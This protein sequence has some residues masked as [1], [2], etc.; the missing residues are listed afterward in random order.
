V[1]AVKVPMPTQG[2]QHL[3]GV[4]NPIDRDLVAIRS[5]Y[6][7]PSLLDRLEES[8]IDTID[9]PEHEEI[10]ERGSMNFVALGPRRILMPTD[11]PLTRARYEAALVEVHQV[12]VSEYLAAAGGLGC[13]SG[14]VTR[15]LLDP[16]TVDE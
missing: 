10:T 2:V 11:C 9:L 8:G 15:D 4:I 16:E 7:H 5:G 13:L 3:L 1:A 14:I 12:D 6:L